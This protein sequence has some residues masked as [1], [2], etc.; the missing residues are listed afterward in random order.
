MSMRSLRRTVP[1]A[2]GLVATAGLVTACSGGSTPAAGASGNASAGTTTASIAFWDPYPQYTD[3]SPWDKQVK[4]CAPKGSTI[5]RT[6]AAQTDLFNQLTTAVKEG[7]AP[8]VAMLDNPMMPEAVSAGLVATADQA[9]ISTAGVDANLLGPGVVGGK[10]YGVPLGS[11]ALGLYYNENV[12][13]KAGVD[14][15]SVTDWATLNVAIE[16]VVASGAKGITFSGISGEEGV[17]QFLPWFWGA[18]ADLKSIGSDQAVAAGQLVSSWIGKGW[19]PKSAATDNQSAS[20]DL[21]LTGEYGF[22]ENGSWFASAASKTDKFTTGVMAIPAKDGGV[23]PVPTGGEFAIAP[24]Q[25]TDASNHYANA[26]AVISC[27]TGGAGGLTSN[28]TLGYLSAKADVRAQQVAANALWKP[29]VNAVEGAKGRT[30]DLGAAYVN[31]SAS[32]S[33]AIQGSLNAAGDASAVKTAFQDAA[34][35]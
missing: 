12:L 17:F 27:L 33:D 26:A 21:F 20:W 10:A 4:S 19:A 8:D 34:A 13:T 32:L 29:W 7:N 15:A 22:A 9:G 28:E 30:T 3:G 14:P 6:S 31:T 18:K 35:K 23:A 16:K 5:T 11:N 2:V 1:I 24:L 25:K